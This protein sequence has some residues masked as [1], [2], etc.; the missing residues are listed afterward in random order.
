MPL[1]ATFNRQ[2]AKLD[3]STV[4]VLALAL[5]HAVLI[6]VAARLDSVTWDEVGHFAAGLSHWQ[7]GR[8]GLYQ[9][10]P[11]LVRM[12]A[13]LPVQRTEAGRLAGWV[14][15][16]EFSSRPEFPIGTRLASHL[17]LEYFRLVFWA[18]MAC[19]PFSLIGLWFSYRWARE[20]YGPRSGLLAALLWCFSPNILAHGHLITPDAGATALGLGA[21][22]AFWRW[23]QGPKLDLTLIAG[24]ALGLA[25]LTKFTWVILFLLWPITW[26]LYRALKRPWTAGTSMLEQGLSLALILFLGVWIMNLGYGFQGS[27]RPLGRYCFASRSLGGDKVVRDSQAPVFNRFAGTRAAFV[28]IPL[29]S[30]YVEG[31]DTQRMDFENKMWSYLRG[32]WRLGG[33]WYYYLYGLLIK[34]PLGTWALIML[35]LTLGLFARGYAAPAGDEL[36]LLLPL[37]S[38]LALV[39]S[40]TGFNHHLRYVLP[41][42]PFAFIWIS[43][44][45]RSLDKGHRLAA[46]MAAAALVCSILSSLSIYP[47]SLSYFNEAVGGP[48]GGHWHLGNSNIDWG[49]DLLNLKRWLAEHAE[50]KPLHLAYDLALMDPRWAGIEYKAPPPGP[51]WFYPTDLSP[52]ALGPQPGWYAISVNQM[53]GKD[54]QF[55][56]FLEF[57][58]AAMAGY[59][60]YIYHVT[61]EE[62]NRVR[63]GLRLPELQ[64]SAQRLLHPGPESGDRAGQSREADRRCGQRRGGQEPDMAP[65]G[66]RLLF[67]MNC[68]WA[69]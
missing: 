60:I 25:E 27:F 49:Q 52:E 14:R 9:A 53:H 20:L 22:Y 51:H 37:F 28:P 18:R 67:L 43:K 45:A 1:R 55:D 17:G 61:L 15:D 59:S 10:N 3:R 64:T 63:R 44:A 11:P 24:L 21:C 65:H 54:K 58:P 56:Y 68:D 30:D 13:C 41:I 36:C 39:S 29:P 31:I 66:A 19:I 26:A 35:A 32:Q 57:K 50:A 7:T 8:F 12:V 38:V 33:W 16:F 2:L 62:A 69:R 47:H 34:V 46:C 23:L 48:K 6:G 42:F 40:Q 5:V 4:I